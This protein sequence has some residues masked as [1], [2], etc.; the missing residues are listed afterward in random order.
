MKEEKRKSML[1]M[2][3]APR[4]GPPLLNND[5]RQNEQAPDFAKFNNYSE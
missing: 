2:L 1:T 5:R 3:L 4:S